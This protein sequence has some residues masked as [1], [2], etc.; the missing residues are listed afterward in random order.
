MRSDRSWWQVPLWSPVHL[1]ATCS[2]IL[3]LLFAAGKLQGSSEATPAP[4][5]SSSSA[6]TAQSPTSSSTSRASA[7]TTP[8]TSATARSS[9]THPVGKKLATPE[10]VAE[11][12]V[13]VWSRR[14]DEPRTWRTGVMALSTPKFAKLLRKTDPLRVPATRSLG[15][16]KLLQRTKKSRVIQ[17][18]TDSGPVAVTTIDI[19]G[20]W[21]VGDIR[22]I[23]K[24]R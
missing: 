3:A 23:E 15:H 12:F 18:S 17:V 7:D 4:S 5:R 2:V 22:P 11:A 13:V 1:L 9:A 8:T 16:P 6:I 10:E 14:Y 19:K 20:R 24:G 21:L